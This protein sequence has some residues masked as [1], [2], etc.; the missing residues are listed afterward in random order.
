MNKQATSTNDDIDDLTAP[1]KSPDAT[2]M[3]SQDGTS[4]DPD[5][6][7]GDPNQGGLDD[8]L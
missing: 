5:E 7:S 3:G 1:E 8:V 2:S 4:Q 6:R